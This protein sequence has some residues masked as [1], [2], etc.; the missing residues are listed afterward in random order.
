[1]ELYGNSSTFWFK[2]F[3]IEFFTKLEPLIPIKFNNILLLQYITAS[4]KNTVNNENEA[5]VNLLLN[6]RTR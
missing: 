3:K 2:N 4:N 5:G 1:M 6:K